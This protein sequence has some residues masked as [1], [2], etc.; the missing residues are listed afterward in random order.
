MGS[1]VV[2]CA[3]R[4]QRVDESE[5][6]RC[7]A[8]LGL[9]PDFTQETLE[10]AYMKK[11][12]ALIRAGSAGEREALRLAHDKLAAHLKT[13]PSVSAPPVA[14]PGSSRAPRPV[15]VP[16]CVPPPPS[17]MAELLNPLSQESWLI[18]LLAL[19][20]VTAIA[21]LVNISPLRFLMSGFHVWMHEFGH[22]TI[23][24]LTGRRALPLPIGWTNIEPERS[25]FVYFGVLFLLGVLAVAGW[26]ERKIWPI[27]IA[28]L[29]APVQFYMTWRMPEHRAD[30][31]V[32]FGGVGGEFY[33]SALFMLL[34]YLQLPDK[35]RWGA[36]R[37]FFLF[38]GASS[39]LHIYLFWQ[40]VKAGA[41]SIPWGSTVQGEEDAG[42]DM[43]I[44]RDDY[45]W[46]N[47]F[48]TGT[49]TGIG[50]A[51]ITVLL[52]SY[53]VFALRI[54]CLMGRRLAALWPE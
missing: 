51:C 24:W 47:H 9:G 6:N 54:D 31:W 49:Y 52:I 41:E 7:C 38:I 40:R 33:L 35:F 28:V 45:N 36:C 4:L 53:L 25:T 8:A 30:L 21:W 13:H 18:N 14:P 5:H 50:A 26:R 42:G 39:F 16:V 27:L 19:P 23:A 1:R 12:F 11:N 34:F 29:V 44:L 37:Y 17:P 48:I 32:A 10:R 2:H 20:V 3:A 22:A 46:S 15:S 43:N